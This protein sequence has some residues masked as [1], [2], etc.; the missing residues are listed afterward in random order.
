[1]NIDLEVVQ[2][3][4]AHETLDAVAMAQVRPE[5]ALVRAAIDPLLANVALAQV[6]AEAT[7]H[8]D[9]AATRVAIVGR[10]RHGR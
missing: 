2:V 10:R 7:R 3:L 6:V 4:V 5:T 1:M 8:A 9:A